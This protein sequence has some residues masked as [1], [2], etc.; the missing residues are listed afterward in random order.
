MSKYAKNKGR[1][2]PKFVML[3]HDI[4]DSLAYRSLDA[5]AR[6]VLHEIARRYNGNNNGQIPL[7]CR[8]A[9]ELVNISKD[10]ASRAFKKLIT[11]GFIK[12]H[13]DNYLN[14]INR[15]SRRWAITYEQCDESLATNEWRKFKGWSDEKDAGV[16]PQ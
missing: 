11:A 13:E 8:E 16:S 10:T 7:S 2:G 12:E 15:K 3:R 9:A 14:V 1:S 5:V 6:C 4:M